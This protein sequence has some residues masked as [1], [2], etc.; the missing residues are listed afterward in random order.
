MSSSTTNPPALSNAVLEAA[1]G[2][3]LI[4]FVAFVIS[5]TLYGITLLQGIYYF[6][7]Y[8]RDPWYLKLLSGVL[9][10]LD[11]LTTIFPAHVL[12]TYLIKDFGTVPKASS[13]PW[14]L[15]AEN[16]VLGIITLLVQC[17]YAHQIWAVSKQRILVGVMIFLIIA[18]F[19]FRFEIA[20]DVWKKP[21]DLLGTDP[22]VIVPS[23]LSVGVGALVDIFITASLCWFLHS[24]RTGIKQTEKLI[25]TLIIIAI[26]R[27]LLTTIAQISNT[28]VNSVIATKLYWYPFHLALSKL[29][30]NSYLAVLNLRSYVTNKSDVGANLQT[31]IKFKSRPALSSG[32]S[33]DVQGSSQ[34]SAIA[35]DGSSTSRTELSEINE[36]EEKE[37]RDLTS[38]DIYTV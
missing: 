34:Q 6:R 16:F 25:D 21:S 23:S 27:A 37:H 13:Q 36:G 12:Y 24:N 11:S 10:I 4:I 22:K 1:K 35:I 3:Y 7:T 18:T 33:G 2:E 19:A 32:F 15:N 38:R 26:N 28:I 5:T 30:T 17:F 31:T 14:S 20:V 9:L 8:L 29:Y